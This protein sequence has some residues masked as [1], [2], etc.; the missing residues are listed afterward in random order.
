MIGDVGQAAWEEV[1]YASTAA[2][3]GR[4]ANFGWNQ[5]E[6][7]RRYPIDGTACPLNGTG[8]YFGPIHQYSNP[9]SS[10]ASVT[11]GYVVRDPSLEELVGKYVY[12]D[13]CSGQVRRL[14]VPSGGGNALLFTAPQFNVATFGEDACG[15]VYVAELSTG[16]VSRLVDGSS[17]C[18]P[19]VGGGPGGGGGSGGG[20]T[21]AVAPD[22]R[23]PLLG[24]RTGSRQRVLRNRGVIVRVRCD[25]RCAYRVT[26]RLNIKL[27]GRTI[28]LRQRVG[29]L[30]ANSTAR[31]RIRL[32]GPSGRALR[33]AL[34]RRKRVR[35][36]VE[37]RV[38]DGSGNL[39]RGSRRLGLVR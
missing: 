7:D 14:D 19:P 33:R 37:V 35:A 18:G 1:D 15:H 21:P 23:S 5:C 10:C 26:G 4:A 3:S 8:R 34:R 24:L 2:G 22:L 17:S 32:S 29:S 28:R 38:R 13:Y 16:V 25:E 30:A 11:G 36:R 39:T 12:A 9:P 27:R 6:A 31:L 20:G